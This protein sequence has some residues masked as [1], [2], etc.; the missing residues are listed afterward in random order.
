MTTWSVDDDDLVGFGRG[1]R[2]THMVHVDPAVRGYEVRGGNVFLVA[3]VLAG[4]W[5][6]DVPDGRSFGHPKRLG[7]EIGHG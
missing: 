4:T 6:C 5:T 2:S 3:P 7:I 1:L